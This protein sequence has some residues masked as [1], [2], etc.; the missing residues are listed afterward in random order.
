[1]YSQISHQLLFSGAGAG[2]TLRA[3]IDGNV[4]AS[5]SSPSW[6]FHSDLRAKKHA[7]AKMFHDFRL[8][9][10]HIDRGVIAGSE[11]EKAGQRKN[12]LC[13]RGE[14]ATDFLG[15]NSERTGTPGCIQK[16]G[17]CSEDDL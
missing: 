16:R 1:M 6:A 10:R 12:I 13:A 14:I 7:F 3:K 4:V 5:K 2:A 8:N 17:P 11:Y 15:V 9:H